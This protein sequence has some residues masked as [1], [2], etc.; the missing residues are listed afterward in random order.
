M[1]GQMCNMIE[2]QPQEEIVVNESQRMLKLGR[3]SYHGYEYTRSNLGYNEG[4]LVILLKNWA[5]QTNASY[6]VVDL[7]LMMLLTLCSSSDNCA[8]ADL[9][10]SF[11]IP[12]QN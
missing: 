2:I 3:K 4:R 12:V 6:K 1:N 10:K 9:T 7:N 11:Q 5:R 8:L